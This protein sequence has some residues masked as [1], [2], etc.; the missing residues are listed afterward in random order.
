MAPARTETMSDEE[1]TPPSA[2]RAARSGR[3]RPLK[4]FWTRIR[5][6][7]VRSRFVKSGIAMGLTVG[8]RVVG[9]T[10]P[11]LPGSDSIERVLAENG[12]VIGAFWH[13]QHLMAPLFRPSDAKVVALFSRSAD[14]E[15]NA[16]VAERLGVEVVRGSGGRANWQ[17]V[18]KG[19]ARALLALKKALDAG[20]SVVMIADI[21]HGTPR[22]AGLGIV[23]LARISG[24]PIV[25][26]AIATTRRHVMRRTW[27]RMTINLPFGRS[28]LVV[29]TPIPVPKDADP[30]AMES[31]RRR[32]SDELNKATERAYALADRA[33]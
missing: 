5:G 14:A 1:T 29:G 23:T 9:W 25:P 18:E 8:A 11:A 33:R 32:L 26:I 24:R 30:A 21:P 7:L 19:G 22:E 4:L 10:N 12:P 2:P 17:A 31:V 28:A 6:P 13:G 16:Q 27:D 15:L 3:P 20:K